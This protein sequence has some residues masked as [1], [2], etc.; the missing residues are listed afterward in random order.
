MKAFAQNVFRG[1]AVLSPEM[2]NGC[3]RRFM[4]D[5][6][7]EKDKRWFY[8]PVR[9]DFRAVASTDNAVK[10]TLVL[11]GTIAGMPT[12]RIV[13]AELEV[14]SDDAEI[15]Y[16]DNFDTPTGDL[17]VTGKGDATKKAVVRYELATPLTTERTFT[18]DSYA[19]GAWSVEAACLT[20]WCAVDRFEGVGVPA[21]EPSDYLLDDADSL[22]TA[23]SKMN[24]FETAFANVCNESEGARSAGGITVVQMPVLDHTGSPAA[25]ENKQWVPKRG[26]TL[27]AAKLY[28]ACDS[29]G[30]EVYCTIKED[31][32]AGS[33][34]RL[35]AVASTSGS[36]TTYDS[37]ENTGDIVQANADS[38]TASEDWEIEFT[39]AGYSDTMWRAFVILYWE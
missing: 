4:Q 20:L 19:S 14:Y 27:T 8:F 1:G 39:R 13:G 2:I 15:F 24:A 29:V 9:L 32:G 26:R 16:I 38:D 30:N 3:H 5:F 17:R 18:L 10:R 7:Y 12:T 25:Y 31:N 36:T 22:A 33:T 6:R 23:R 37:D 28:V 11:D 35:L 34:L 21:T